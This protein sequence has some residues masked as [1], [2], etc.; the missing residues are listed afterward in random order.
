MQYVCLFNTMDQR[1]SII[2]RLN[3]NETSRKT[4]APEHINK[5]KINSF[6]DL[7]LIYS[8]L[9]SNIVCLLCR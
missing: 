4:F 6:F 3:L 2:T 8:G 5:E 1:W 7:K 9:P